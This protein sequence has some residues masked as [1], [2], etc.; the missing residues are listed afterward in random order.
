M[1]TKCPQQGLDA[2]LQA[3]KWG[4]VEVLRWLVEVGG[5]DVC[6]AKVRASCVSLGERASDSEST[7]IVRLCYRVFC[8]ILFE[9]RN[10]NVATYQRVFSFVNDRM[11][12]DGQ[13][14]TSPETVISRAV[15]WK[16]ILCVARWLILQT[17]FCTRCRK[18]RGVSV[19]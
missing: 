5:M 1:T 3:C 15:Q 10:G 13:L 7:D 2:C 4:R 18:G 19:F 14:T 12:K 16:T 8:M 9:P 11:R 17:A 6:S